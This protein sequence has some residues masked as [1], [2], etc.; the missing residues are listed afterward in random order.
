MG[1]S[2]VARGTKSCAK[3]EK[4]PLSATVAPHSSLL[5]GL[6]PNA[7]VQSLR[8]PAERRADRVSQTLYVTRMPRNRNTALRNWIKFR[9]QRSTTPYKL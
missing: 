7:D 1:K 5:P 4:M 9:Y 3:N 8:P 2:I 6:N